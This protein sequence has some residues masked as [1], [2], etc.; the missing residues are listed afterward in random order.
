MSSSPIIRSRCHKLGSGA[1]TF[2]EEA[3]AAFWNVDAPRACLKITERGC[4]VFDQPQQFSID[5]GVEKVCRVLRLVFDTAALHSQT[6]SQGLR[7]SS[8]GLRGSF[9]SSMAV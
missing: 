7:S 8:I 4:V 2:C 6:V 5:L 9:S 3:G 1:F